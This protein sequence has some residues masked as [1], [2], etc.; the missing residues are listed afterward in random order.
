MID[1]DHAWNPSVKPVIIGFVI[2]LIL[3]LGV[4]LAVSHK[5]LEGSLL[6]IA[7]VAAGS[8]Q[9][10]VQLIFFMHLGLEA[11]PRWHSM[12]FLF[13]LL[14]GFV[15]VGGSLWIMYN[16]N[17]NMPNMPNMPMGH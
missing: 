9:A 4:Y 17:Y 3:T 8:I 1:L 14:I 11:K 2:S 15:L 10:L 6:I 16:L 7:V 12:T 13:M 5:H